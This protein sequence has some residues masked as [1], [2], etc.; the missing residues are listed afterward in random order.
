MSEQTQNLM[1]SFLD[2][3]TAVPDHVP[4]KMVRYY[5]YWKVFYILAGAGHL[6]ALFNFYIAGVYFMAIFNVFS[7]GLF[8]G[9]YMLL[10]AGYYRLAYWG[11]VIELVLHGIA[12]TVCVGTEFDFGNY[13]FLVPI[14]IFI[15]PFYSRRTSFLLTAVTLSSAVGATAYMQNNEPLYSVPPDLT[16][17][18]ELMAVVNWPIFVLI[19]VLPCARMSP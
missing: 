15:Q 13:V 17:A 18:F 7:V 9:A 1:P 12:A 3:L 16:N 11:A 14:L 4:E 2:R 5:A 19:M 10:K 8:A 6:L